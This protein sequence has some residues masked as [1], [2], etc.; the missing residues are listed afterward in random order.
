MADDLE[1]LQQEV[2]RL[3]ARVQDLSTLVEASALIGSTLDLEKLIELVMEKAQT[4]MR[5]EASS[6]MLVNQALNKLDC[7][8]ALGVV[9][10]QVQEIVHLDK[11]QGLAGW[12]WEHGEPLNVPDVRTDARFYGGVDRESGFLSRS[13]LSV[14]LTVQN[15]IIGVAQVINRKDGRPFS[16][17]DV[18]LF[19]GF[20][21]QVALAIDTAQMHQIAL[22]QERMN[23]QLELAQRVQQSFLPQTLPGTSRDP[24]RI[25]AASLPAIS[26]GGDFYDAVRLDD[27]HLALIIGDVSGK[28]VPAALFMARMMSD[29]RFYVQQDARPLAL[30]QRLNRCVLQQGHSGLFV[31]V[32]YLVIDLHR[33]EVRFCD[34]GHLPLIHIAAQGGRAV[35]IAGRMG[36]PLGILQKMRFQT[37]RILL[38]QG[39]F[40]FLYTDGLIE[41]RDNQQ[42]AFTLD[43]LQAE[44]GRRWFD[45]DDLLNGLFSAV[46]RFSSEGPRLDDMTALVFQWLGVREDDK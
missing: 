21:R 22:E 12:V 43:R 32:Q 31:T 16:E 7:K 13:I 3:R 11:G 14:P 34:A 25:S 19:T 35:R 8:V 36:G 28:G 38:Q 40:L 20:C 24:F 23:Q 27:R 17:Q 5:A 42:R 4:V 45:C 33:G 41:A 26:V 30:I 1:A 39:D 15:R 9:G 2:A 37:Q 10:K 29:F 44:A 46:H 6:V 18:E